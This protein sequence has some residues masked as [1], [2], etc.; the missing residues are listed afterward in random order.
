MKPA[1]CPSLCACDGCRLEGYAALCWE[2][3]FGWA[4]HDDGKH[5]RFL[6]RAICN[7]GRC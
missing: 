3:Y 6:A 7:G 5:L 1:G 4:R 2:F